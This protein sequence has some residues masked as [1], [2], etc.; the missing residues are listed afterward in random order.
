MYKKCTNSVENDDKI[1][2]PYTFY[3]FRNNVPEKV[4]SPV[5]LISKIGQE[6]NKS[7]S[8]TFCLSDK[9]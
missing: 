2:Y 5:N 7:S 6:C 3:E 8:D 4:M 9:P 1:E